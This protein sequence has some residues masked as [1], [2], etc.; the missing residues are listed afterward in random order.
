MKIYNSTDIKLGI[1]RDIKKQ[2]VKRNI[3]FSIGGPDR[4]IIFLQCDDFAEDVM[5][6]PLY[7]PFKK[8]VSYNERT[9]VVENEFE[10]LTPLLDYYGL[11]SFTSE[12]IKSFVSEYLAQ[13][14]WLRKNEELFGVTTK[15]YGPLSLSTHNDDSILPYSLY[16]LLTS[17]QSDKGYNLTKKE[18]KSLNLR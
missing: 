14:S 16:E 8:Q 2:I 15:K 5:Y 13:K 10:S 9:S 18:K 6:P 11:S 1:L 7:Y 4:G 12:E 17:I 3:T